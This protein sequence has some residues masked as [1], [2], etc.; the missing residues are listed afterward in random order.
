VGCRRSDPSKLE[1][2]PAILARFEETAHKKQGAFNGDYSPLLGI[3]QGYLLRERERELKAEG[4]EAQGTGAVTAIS[5]AAPLASVPVE[6][7][8]VVN[9]AAVVEE[10][11][12]EETAVVEKKAAVDG[13]CSDSAVRK[14]L[15]L[16]GEL[17]H[18]VVARPG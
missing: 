5:T 13:M 15:E 12:V 9:E 4:G 16:C 8:V 1:K 6:Q 18:S 14:R 10:K 3:V 7:K 17:G 11:A 2:V